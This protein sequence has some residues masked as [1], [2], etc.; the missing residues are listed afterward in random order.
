MKEIKKFKDEISGEEFTS[1][2]QAIKS[3]NRSKDIKS[4]FAFYINNKNKPKDGNDGIGVKHEEEFYYRLIDTLIKLV[5]KYDRWILNSYE[6]V[7]GLSR[8]NVKGYSMLGRF[9]DDSN[10]GLYHWWCIQSNICPK[11]YREYGQT[12]YALHCNCK[13]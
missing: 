9:L 3:E 6:D 1:E 13:K 12:Y 4:S 11:C 7:G 8:E 5:K 10:S 2:Q